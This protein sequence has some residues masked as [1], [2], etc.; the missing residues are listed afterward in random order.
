MQPHSAA[1]YGASPGTPGYTID[2]RNPSSTQ[3]STYQGSD[4]R[5]PDNGTDMQRRLDQVFDDVRN[6]VN[7]SES[8]VRRQQMELSNEASRNSQLRQQLYGD[9]RSPQVSKFN[10]DMSS[11][12][13]DLEM[14]LRELEAEISTNRQQ[15]KAGKGQTG[16]ENRSEELSATYSQIEEANFLHKNEAIELNHLN[17]MLRIFEEENQRLKEIYRKGQK[18]SEVDVLYIKSNIERVRRE[19]EEIL[20][21]RAMLNQRFSE[22]VSVI[23]KLQNENRSLKSHQHRQADASQVHELIDQLN[24]RN[25]KIS[26][27]NN[28]LTMLRNHMN[29][30]QRTASTS[31]EVINMKRE[32]DMRNNKV[33]ELEQSLATQTHNCSTLMQSNQ[34]LSKQLF[35]VKK[36]LDTIDT[37][38]IRGELASN[39]KV[40][41]LLTR[42]NDEMRREMK[43]QGSAQQQKNTHETQADQAGDDKAKLGQEKQ[44]DNFS[45]PLR[46]ITTIKKRVGDDIDEQ[47]LL[48]RTPMGEVSYE[49]M[50]KLED[51]IKEFGD[52][53]F[54]LEE[55]IYKLKSKIQGT[56][57]NPREI[58]DPSNYDS[59]RSDRKPTS[60]ETERLQ[61]MIC[62]LT[63]KVDT[64][65]GSSPTKATPA[66]PELIIQIENIIANTRKRE[67]SDLKLLFIQR[68]YQ[69]VSDE[70]SDLKERY[71]QL[72][73]KYNTL[74][75][76]NLQNEA[77]IEK[78]I[79]QIQDNKA[80]FK[81]LITENESLKIKERDAAQELGVWVK[82]NSELNDLNN[83]LSRSNTSL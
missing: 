34:G 16:L 22:Q 31:S 17:N 25:A 80:Y 59:N 6:Q 35:E 36:Q 4:S 76:V 44:V 78:L 55:L 8:A 51:R 41:D 67:E 39:R 68:S 9:N 30:Q 12:N 27:L 5:L 77:H 73:I 82:Q 66:A 74:I 45:S 62:D 26:E 32:L 3:R 20:R 15:A 64:L 7:V 23:D 18:P 1:R 53:N 42:E 79:A 61:K 43:T 2:P 70:L 47:L 24:T 46:N 75:P 40:I 19:I 13:Q 72:E 83:D 21:A 52:C 14:R 81:K 28:E 65:V 50:L 56:D 69:Q 54:D 58:V 57:Y 38:H 33:R 60:R 71:R 10:A 49:E 48:E 37:T 11:E 29:A 63:V